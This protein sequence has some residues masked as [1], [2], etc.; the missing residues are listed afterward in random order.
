MSELGDGDDGVSWSS[1][2]MSSDEFTYSPEA[3]SSV[4]PRAESHV[5]IISSK[6]S[7]MTGLVERAT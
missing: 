4:S 5:V 2:S 3:V 7:R 1:N 6:R